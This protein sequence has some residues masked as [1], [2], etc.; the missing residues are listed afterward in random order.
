M[1]FCAKC[2]SIL[3]PTRDKNGILMKCTCGYSSRARKNVMIKEEVSLDRDDI[4]EVVDKKV[5]TLPKTKEECPKCGNNV[6]FFWT[7]QTRA[8]DEAETRFFE[9]TKC[10]H[11]WRSY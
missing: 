10:K 4:I 8:S 5:D 11:R 9:C 3:V 2:G 1:M 7:L 6:A